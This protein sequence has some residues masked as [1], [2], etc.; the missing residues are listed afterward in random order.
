VLHPVID[1]FERAAKFAR[2]DAPSRKLDKLETLLAQATTNVV[3]AAPLIAALLAIPANGRYPPLS[4]SP[5]R[6]KERTLEILLEQLAGLARR[7]PV[8]AIHED[9]HWADPTTLE[10][11][12]LVIDRV[13]A[14]PVLVII[15]FRPEFTPLWLGHAHVTLLSLSRL[16]RR[17]G[18]AMVEHLTG[19]KALPT[20]VLEQIVERTDG[21]PL[22]LEEL[23]KA[24]LELGLL[25]EEAGSYALAGPLPPLA[26]PST[27]QDSLMAR[28]DR[29]APVREVAQIGSVIGREFSHELLAAVVDLPDADLVDAMNQLASTGLVFR[30][31]SPTHAS[32]LFKHALVQDAAYNSLLISRRQQLHGRI[33]QVLEERFPDTSAVEPELLAHHFSQAGLVEKA[34]EYHERAGRRAISQSAVVEALAQFDRALARLQGLPPSKERQRREL[35]IQLALGSGHVAVHGFTARATGDAYRRAAELCE[36]LGEARELFPVLYGLCLY[37]LYGAELAQAKAVGE[38]LLKLAETTDDHGLLFFAHRAAGVSALPAGDFAKARF[39]LERALQLYDPAE[40]RTPAF[41]YAIDPRVVCLDY[42]ART[43]LPL[44]FPEQALAANDEAVREARLLSHRNSLALPLFF[45]GVVHQIIG[46]REGVE[47]RGRELAEIAGDAGF[48]FWQ[49][50]ATVLSGWAR[51]E[52]GGLEDGRLEIKRGVDEWCGTGAEYMLPY[53]LALLAQ[54]ECRAGRAQAA[55]SLLEEALSRVE[56]TGERWFE[57]EIFRIE[58]E[59]L[60]TLGRLTDTR[61]SLRRA[62][63][64]AARQEARFWELRAALSRVRID[65]DVG[66][67]ERVACLCTAFSEGFELPDLQAARA[68]AFDTAG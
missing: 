12:D 65:G 59:V 30:R 43:L 42:L 1:L 8:L 62:V 63:E 60:S 56:R 4:V 64:T 54:V 33:A 32:Y 40:H 61:A 50:G 34:I 27:L 37:H 58:G 48:R 26:I 24:V 52:A 39:H 47:V 51:A 5:Q 49:A 7:Q 19:G 53:F 36:E 17:Q 11:L 2:D 6:Q 15:T 68:L 20:E 16:G 66:A 41:I 21:V 25:K 23:T 45:G 10:L 67:R 14:L 44:G 57:A 28:L 35:S 13:R 9:V 55:L 31:G 3:D 29:L 22:F 38:R 46:D 18:A